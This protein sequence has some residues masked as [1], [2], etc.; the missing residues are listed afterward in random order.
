VQYQ[1]LRGRR[2]RYVPG[3]DCHGLPIELK[4]L[5]ALS[6]EQRRALSPL[7][8]RRK[9][10][11]F[12]LRTV[13]AQRAQFQRCAPARPP[14]HARPLALRFRLPGRPSARALCAGTASGATGT[15]PT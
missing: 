6:A 2:A 4:V 15:R 11:D 5:Q 8:L 9:A 1:L 12:A 10:H 14:R 7:Q 13:K 3:W